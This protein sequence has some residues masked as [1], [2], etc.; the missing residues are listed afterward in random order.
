MVGT[1][2]ISLEVATPATVMLGS[3]PAQLEVDKVIQVCKIVVSY[4]VFL[5]R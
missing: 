5:K 1:C 2:N 3:L 4:F